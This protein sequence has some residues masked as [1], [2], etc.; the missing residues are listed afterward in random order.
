VPFFLALGIAVLFVSV[1][2]RGPAFAVVGLVVGV[3]SLL[4]WTWHTEVDL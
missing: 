1:L 3:V 2:V 4:R